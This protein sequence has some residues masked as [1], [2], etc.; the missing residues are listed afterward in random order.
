MLWEHPQFMNEK[1]CN[2]KN[3]LLELYEWCI[4]K[5]TIYQA[6]HRILQTKRITLKMW[7]GMHFFFWPPSKCVFV[8][9][10]VSLKYVQSGCLG[11]LLFSAKISFLVKL[12]PSWIHL[13]SKIHARRLEL[14]S[15][16]GHLFSCWF[17]VTGHQRKGT[18]SC[19]KRKSLQ[20]GNCKLIKL[21][22]VL[23][24]LSFDG[25]TLYSHY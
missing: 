22:F 3:C 1:G 5:T 25:C 6:L 15:G 9:S 12:L 16:S 19:N 23:L 21:S 8:F 18:L 14:P 2:H 20:Y 7:I 4:N 17:Y 10:A 11:E 24:L 13:L